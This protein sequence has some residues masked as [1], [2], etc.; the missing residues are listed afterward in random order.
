MIFERL[1]RLLSVPKGFGKFYPKGSG[2]AAGRKVK[3][4]KGLGGGGSGGNGGGPNRENWEHLMG[5]GLSTAAAGLMYYKLK[6]SV[7]ER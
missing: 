2:G 1:G 6:D 4:G 7:S 3:S 5:V